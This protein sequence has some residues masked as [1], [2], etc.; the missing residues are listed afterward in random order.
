MRQLF[1]LT[2]MAFSPYCYGVVDVVL[3]KRVALLAHRLNH[4]AARR[5]LSRK[6]WEC[7]ARR[8]ILYTALSTH[9]PYRLLQASRR[10]LSP[11]STPLQQQRPSWPPPPSPSLSP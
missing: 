1:K 4:E 10:L 8:S 9:T 6:E 11:T 5:H 2:D 3:E 7:F